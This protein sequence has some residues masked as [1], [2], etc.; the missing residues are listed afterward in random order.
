MGESPWSHRRPIA[1]HATSHLTMQRSLRALNVGT[2]II[3]EAESEDHG[4]T[5]RCFPQHDPNA[6]DARSGREQS[7]VLSA[8]CMVSC[9]IRL[10]KP[11][12]YNN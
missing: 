7:V 4:S 10:I 11:E 5:R 8:Y 6:C 9:G 1:R 12:E 3:G 2:R